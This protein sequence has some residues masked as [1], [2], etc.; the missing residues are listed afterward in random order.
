M[1]PF[2]HGFPGWIN[3][4]VHFASCSSIAVDLAINSPPL[5]LRKNRGTARVVKSLLRTVLTVF[6][7]MCVETS[8]AKHSLV[9][10]STMLKIRSFVPFIQLS[11]MISIVQTSFGIVAPYGTGVP[12]RFFR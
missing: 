1:N 7:L 8:R 6:E 12:V 11:W 3:R 9:N 4:A 10:S 5:S 2:C